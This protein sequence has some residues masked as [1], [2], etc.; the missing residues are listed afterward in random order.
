VSNVRLK[1]AVVAALALAA[2]TC[3]YPGADAATRGQEAPRVNQDALLIADFTKRVQD[4]Q[5]LHEKL[6][7]SLP[8]RP[9]KLT[10]GEVDYH[11]RALGRLI[12]QERA[13]AAHGDVFTKDNRAY[14][15]RQ[16]ARALSGPDGPQMRRAIMD[17]N[18]GGIQLRINSR[19][20]DEIPIVTMPPQ[21]LA[22][23]P[24]LPQELEFRFIGRRLILLDAHARLVVD[25]IDD[26]LPR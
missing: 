9:D 14:F 16:I 15:R 18:P 12:A 22:A 11:E 23:L 24:K 26:A 1:Q 7:R 6:E 8:S 21:I 17:E 13:R 10:P 25:Y 3:L 4:Y 5:D 20:P 2:L 19:Y